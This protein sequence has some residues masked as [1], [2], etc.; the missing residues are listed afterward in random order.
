MPM[1]EI[2]RLAKAAQKVRD[3]QKKYYAANKERITA[4]QRKY[5]Y[6]NREKIIAA[7]QKYYV[8]NKEKILEQRRLKREQKKREAIRSLLNTAKKVQEARKESKLDS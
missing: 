3:S 4:T 8:D 1:E 7:K 6:A 5:Y 2:V